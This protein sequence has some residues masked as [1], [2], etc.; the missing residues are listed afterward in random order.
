[1]IEIWDL[2]Q[3]IAKK[4]GGSE[5]IQV[6]ISVLGRM[7]LLQQHQHPYKFCIASQH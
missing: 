1:M 2:N 3:I 4:K 7:L 5:K 6:Y